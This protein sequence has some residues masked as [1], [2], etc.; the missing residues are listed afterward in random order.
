MTTLNDYQQRKIQRHESLWT[1]GQLQRTKHKNWEIYQLTDPT[2]T[3]NSTYVINTGREGWG[4]CGKPQGSRVGM[5]LGRQPLTTFDNLRAKKI[6]DF[7][8]YRKIVMSSYTMVK[9]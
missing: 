4:E 5:F 9:V 8:E 1:Q 2:D 6:A 7:P 3:T